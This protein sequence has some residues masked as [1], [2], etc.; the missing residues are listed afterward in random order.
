MQKLP[1]DFRY[2]DL[3]FDKRIP[4]TVYANDGTPYVKSIGV[5]MPRIPE[6]SR[7]VAVYLFDSVQS[8]AKDALDGCATGF[9]ISIPSTKYPWRYGYCVT[10]AHAIADGITVIRVNGKNGSKP[11]AFDLDPSDWLKHPDGFDIAVTE[12]PIAIN[13]DIHDV[14][15]VDSTKIMTKELAKEINLGIGDDV[16][17]MGRFINEEHNLTN[18]P[19]VR[20]GHISVMPSPLLHKGTG[21]VQP[22]YLLDMHSRSGF[23]GS[24]VFMYRTPYGDID[25]AMRKGNTAP[26]GTHLY[27]LGIH[28]G[29]YTDKQEI[30]I[31]NFKGQFDGLSGMT[32]IDPAENIVEMLY[33]KKFVDDRNRRDAIAIAERRDDGVKL[34]SA[35]AETP[36]VTG[37]DLLAV[38][39]NTPPTPH[40]GAA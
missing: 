25:D 13:G 39:L 20:F 4:I 5:G 3:E 28:W 18:S 30:V 29:Q 34:E 14:S 2:R 27:F 23:S 7:T 37:D 17:M 1:R 8:A 10:N 32:M 38:M 12:N 11:T 31:G 26:F 33:M 22:S 35:K 15:I 9:F 16:F 19:A 36:Q 6:D 40:K 21:K 24:P